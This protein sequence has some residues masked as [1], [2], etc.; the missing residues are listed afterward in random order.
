MTPSSN[1]HDHWWVFS[2]QSLKISTKIRKKETREKKKDFDDKHS[3]E[4]NRELFVPLLFGSAIDAGLSYFPSPNGYSFLYLRKKKGMNEAHCS[5]CCF[6]ECLV[7]LLSSTSGARLLSESQ[8]ELQALLK[9]I[10]GLQ[11]PIIARDIKIF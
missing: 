1:I 9:S 4:I 2:F 8:S 6:V 7:E 5:R 3:H 11:P 10:Y